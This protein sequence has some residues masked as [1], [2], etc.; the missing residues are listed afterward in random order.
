[1]TTVYRD[2][3]TGNI[4]KVIVDEVLSGSQK[5]GYKTNDLLNAFKGS[6]FIV[7]IEYTEQT[8]IKQ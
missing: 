4:T 7:G 1:M 3:K 5:A 2:M 6:N 8:G